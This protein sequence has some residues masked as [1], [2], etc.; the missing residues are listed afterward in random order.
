MHAAVAYVPQQ[1]QEL[2]LDAASTSYHM[3]DACWNCGRFRMPSGSRY[4]FVAEVLSFAGMHMQ[5]TCIPGICTCSVIVTAVSLS[6]CA[7]FEPY[8]CFCLAKSASR[9]C[10]SRP[11]PSM[12][13]TKSLAAGLVLPAYC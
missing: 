13:I 10:R 7:H 3:P 5:A 2:Q 4:S 6:I 9:D 12:D 1:A 11:W 8:I